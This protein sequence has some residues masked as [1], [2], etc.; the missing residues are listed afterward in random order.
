MEIKKKKK[1]SGQIRWVGEIIFFL[2]LKK[3]IEKKI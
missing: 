2:K 3:N 1:K